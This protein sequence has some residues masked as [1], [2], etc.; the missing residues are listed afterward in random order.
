LT[1][2]QAASSLSRHATDTVLA[3]RWGSELPRERG[4]HRVQAGTQLDNL[5]SQRV[6]IKNGFRQYG[7]AQGYLLFAGDS[8][9]E[10]HL[11]RLATDRVDGQAANY[12]T[13]AITR[14]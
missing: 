8:P 14:P 4:L 9:D 10:V 7:Y 6:L 11:Q 3:R 1:S 13:S 12:P 5:A 2:P